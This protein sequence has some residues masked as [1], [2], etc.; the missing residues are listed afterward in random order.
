MALTG[1]LDAFTELHGSHAQT[2]LGQSQEMSRKV[3]ECSSSLVRAELEIFEGLARKGWAGGGLE[4]LLDRGQDPF[5]GEDEGRG[6]AGTVNGLVPVG[7]Q[8]LGMPRDGEQRAASLADAASLAVMDGRNRD[9]TCI[10]DAEAADQAMGLFSPPPKPNSVPGG[11]SSV[12]E[13]ER[14]LREIADGDDNPSTSPRHDDA[15][16]EES[17][18]KESDAGEQE[19]P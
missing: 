7:Y 18:S 8:S 10:F 15:I 9:E 1:R 6:D 19:L 14:P 16:S 4:E 12:W 5:A 3:V 17:K 2:V 13:S 11:Q